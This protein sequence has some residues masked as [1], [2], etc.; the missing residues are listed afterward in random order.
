MRLFLVELKRYFLKL[1]DLN[2]LLHPSQ[3][4]FTVNDIDYSYIHIL[5]NI[6]TQFVDWDSVFDIATR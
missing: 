4:P 6:I 3:C 1:S 5:F 2:V